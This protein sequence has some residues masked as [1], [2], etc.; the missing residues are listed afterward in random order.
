MAAYMEDLSFFRYTLCFLTRGDEILML[1]RQHPPNQGLW[2]GVGGR[3]EPGESPH[4]SCLREVY[5]ETGYCITEAHFGG[6][7]T[8]E[9][10]ET[11]SGGLYLFWAPAPPGEPAACDEGQLSW[12]KREWVFSSPE[13]VSNIHHFGPLMF[14]NGLPQVYHFVYHQ[15]RI[16]HWEIRPLSPALKVA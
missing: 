11:P 14:A 2:N 8:W 15:N 5:E 3:I 6:V 4:E 1:H 16:A 10:F 9:G 12:K 13:V 7:L